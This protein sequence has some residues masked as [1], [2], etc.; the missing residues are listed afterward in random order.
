[1]S[2][3]QWGL[4]AEIFGVGCLAFAVGEVCGTDL[5]RSLLLAASIGGVWGLGSYFVTMTK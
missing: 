5:V 2:G 3:K 4:L 1:M